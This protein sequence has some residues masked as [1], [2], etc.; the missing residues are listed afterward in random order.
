MTRGLRVLPLT[1]VALAGIGTAKAALYA[2]GDIVTNLT[3]T[4]RRSFPRPDGRMVNAGEQVGI[5]DFPGHIIFLE[6]FAVWCPFCQAA[7]PQVDAGIVDHYAA[8]GGRNSNGVPVLYLF[9]NQESASF[10]PQASGY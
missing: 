9:V 3:F 1:L 8:R 7:V 6:W 4:A 10:Y 2:P 5:K